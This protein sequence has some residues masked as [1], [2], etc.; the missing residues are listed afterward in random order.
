MKTLIALLLIFTGIIIGLH[1]ITFVGYTI[2]ERGRAFDEIHNA[3]K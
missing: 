3:I 1:A 2:A